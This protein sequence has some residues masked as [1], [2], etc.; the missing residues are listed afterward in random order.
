MERTQRTGAM[1]SGLKPGSMSI[2]CDDKTCRL[3]LLLGR[4]LLGSADALGSGTSVREVIHQVVELEVQ[5]LLVR[6][7]R[8]F[9]EAGE[10]S[11]ETALPFPSGIVSQANQI[12]R[13][14][15]CEDG[16]ATLP[17]KLQAHLVI[18]E[19]LEV[20]EVPGSLEVGETWRVVNR[21]VGVKRVSQNAGK[22]PIL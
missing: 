5:V 2:D 1:S 11:H 18:K 20:D 13:N 12:E 10:L 14:R 16:V 17:G 22:H 6:S 3:S 21:H 15:C 7:Q 9:E 4:H 19:A 8:A